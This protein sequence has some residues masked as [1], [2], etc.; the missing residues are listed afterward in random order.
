[1]A[2]FG[3]TMTR[4]AACL[5]LVALL[6]LPGQRAE[7]PVGTPFRIGGA[8]GVDVLLREIDGKTFLAVRAAIPP[9]AEQ[10]AIVR[11]ARRVSAMLRYYDVIIPILPGNTTAPRHMRTFMA[12]RQETL[13]FAP[14]EIAGIQ[15]QILALVSES[16]FGDFK[17]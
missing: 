3:G 14:S 4:C 9:A 13:T 2:D 10:V 12:P 5:L 11:V 15:V 6:P 7:I 1:M 17:P 8:S 16:K